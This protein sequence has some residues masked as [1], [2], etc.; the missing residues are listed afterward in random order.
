ML[1]KEEKRKKHTEYMRKWRAENREKL[2]AY[3]RKH[4]QKNNAHITKLRRIGWQKKKD[5]VN[6]ERRLRHAENPEVQRSYDRLC[7]KL[8]SDKIRAKNRRSYHKHAEKRRKANEK[9]RRE[10]PEVIRA[11]RKL[12]LDHLLEYNRTKRGK[13]A[14]YQ[15]ARKDKCVLCGLNN[16]GSVRRYGRRLD[17][18]HVDGDLKNNSPENLLT[19]CRKCHKRIEKIS[20][21]VVE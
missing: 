13:C 2:L 12:N 8:D 17:V 11:W 1:S 10:H 9:Y 18:H 4:N 16:A 19:V 20:I 6:A 7:W 5:R 3:R 14:P 21:P 15:F